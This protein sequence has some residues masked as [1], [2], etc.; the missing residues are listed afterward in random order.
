MD[1]EEELLQDAPPATADVDVEA[2]GDVEV[3]RL[4]ALEESALQA[5]IEKAERANALDDEAAAARERKEAR[6]ALTAAHT[7]KMESLQERLT[8][9]KRVKTAPLRLLTE[10]YVA[11]MDKGVPRPLARPL[12]LDQ[13]GPTAPP[14][15]PRDAEHPVD[16]EAGYELLEVHGLYPGFHGRFPRIVTWKRIEK[17]RVETYGN[18]W[19]PQETS[20]NQPWEPTH[21]L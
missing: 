2:A 4:R 14:E 18:I 9:L 20:G 7:A 8:D 19:E 5:L 21:Y 16:M 6:E 11:R 12:Q 15:D 17:P 10:S 3:A 13:L 1:L